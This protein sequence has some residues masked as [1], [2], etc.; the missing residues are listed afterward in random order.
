MPER[1][2]WRCLWGNLQ[3]ELA[4]QGARR[5]GTYHEEWDG[6]E[7]SVGMW[8]TAQRSC[9]IVDRDSGWPVEESEVES[10]CQALEI[11]FEMIREHLDPGGRV[12]PRRRSTNGSGPGKHFIGKG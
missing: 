3:E 1:T 8:S 7:E 10:I 11:D 5:T 2:R 9:G 6:E 4:D 12:E